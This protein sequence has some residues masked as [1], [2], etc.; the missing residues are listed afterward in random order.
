MASNRDRPP[1]FM[2]K[3]ADLGKEHIRRIDMLTDEDERLLATHGYE[4]R[5]AL[6]ILLMAIIAAY[7][8]AAPSTSAK[9]PHKTI[10]GRLTDVLRLITRDA[11]S[12][13]RP[14]DADEKILMEVARR[15]AETEDPKVRI[16]TI[17]RDALKSEGKTPDHGIPAAVKRLKR[18]FDERCPILVA[19]AVAETNDDRLDQIRKLRKAAIILSELGVPVCFETLDATVRRQPKR[20][21]MSTDINSDL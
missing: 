18:K 10:E 2:Q 11:S 16:S 20:E 7:D 3:D 17:I 1:K 6:A 15:R 8:K 21:P 14:T 12:R 9:L 4:D 5:S 19:R 13:G